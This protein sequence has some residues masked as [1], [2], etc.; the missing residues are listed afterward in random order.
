MFAGT[1][2]PGSDQFVLT[3]EK[4][5][6]E[7]IADSLGGHVRPTYLKLIYQCKGADKIALVSD[8]CAG[9]DTRGSD[10]NVIDGE[11]Y[12]SQLSLS[13]ALRNMRRHTGASICDLIKMV[14]STPAKT[15]GIFNERG[16]IEPGK[17]ADLVVLDED[18]MVKGVL[19]EGSFIRKDF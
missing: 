18:L 7:V 2:E 6:A 19:L 17:F 12:G 11:L 3:E 8:C 13:V 10:V 5:V 9:G 14:T 15:I 4:M 1:R 16:S